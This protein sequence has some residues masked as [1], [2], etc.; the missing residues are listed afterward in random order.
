MDGPAREICK[1]SI[2][3]NVIVA[4]AGYLEVGSKFDGNVT[5]IDDMIR[6]QFN[7]YR[8]VPD[9]ITHA[10]WLCLGS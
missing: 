8:T 10:E 3:D 4:E 1:I 5:K 6:A 9:K 2:I 7:Q